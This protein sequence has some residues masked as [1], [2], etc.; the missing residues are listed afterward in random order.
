MQ[1]VLALVGAIALVVAAVAIRQL[2]A[3]EDGGNGSGGGG[4]DDDATVV[5]CLTELED[6][7]RDLAADADG[8]E[9]VVE[10]AGDTMAKLTAGDSGYDGWITFEPWPEVVAIDEPEDALGA[11]SGPVAS[12]EL[13][14][15]VPD[16]ADPCPG[17]DPVTWR[18]LGDTGAKVGLPPRTTG[19]GL[20]LVGNAASG[21]FGRTD[22]A[23]NDFDPAFD[24]WLDVVTGNPGRGD[25]FDELLLAFPPTLVFDAVGTTSARF[26]DE[27]P[28]SRA[29]GRLE[30]VE[31]DPLAEATVVVVSV[32]GSG[33]EER[34]AELADDP[35]LV[36]AL[37][38]SGWS[39]G[40]PDDTGL[41]SA[42]VLY[43]LLNR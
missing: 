37:A 22:F 30:P 25:P 23:T 15:V 35:A 3:G 42:G 17:A 12:T 21:Y 27:V 2:I 26:D 19:V 32:A 31:P 14:L 8:I 13:V 16:T 20:L 24:Q 39:D 36:D 1:R 6:A 9:V 7:C 38:A 4:G 5:A 40:G 43:A 34:V 28:G 11:P 33:N 10:D 18:C 41:P 29:D